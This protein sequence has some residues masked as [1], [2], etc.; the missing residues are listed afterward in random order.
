MENV[1]KDYRVDADL[2]EEEV[3][4]G[5]KDVQKVANVVRHVDG[6]WRSPA[7]TCHQTAQVNVGAELENAVL[8]FSTQHLWRESRASTSLICPSPD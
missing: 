3:A 8:F 5:A 2:I 6:S 7:F 1:R 4:D